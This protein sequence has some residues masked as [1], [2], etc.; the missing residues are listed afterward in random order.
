MAANMS[1]TNLQ[2]FENLLDSLASETNCTNDKKRS[3]DNLNTDSN[4]KSDKNESFDYITLKQVKFEYDKT[5][6]NHF[7]EFYVIFF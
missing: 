4:Y 2:D 5:C 7:Y 1:A 6:L 3:N